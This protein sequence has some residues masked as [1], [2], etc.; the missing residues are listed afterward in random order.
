IEDS[1]DFPDGGFCRESHENFG[2]VVQRGREPGLILHN[3]EQ[4]K[5]LQAWGAQILA[6]IE[7]YA[8]ILDRA[9][10]E[11]IYR[12]AL[13]QQQAKIENPDLT[14]SARIHAELQESGLGIQE[15]TLQQSQQ[16]HE[17]L[18]QHTLDATTQHEFKQSVE[19]SFIDKQALED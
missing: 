12:H 19:Q 13:A 11:N 8:D 5:T 16:H 9:Y 6:G 10:G 17:Q 4:P 2:T 1:P 14:P 18:I 3:E 7:P 15:Y